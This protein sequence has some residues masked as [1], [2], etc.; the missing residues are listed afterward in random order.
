VS[1]E[2]LLYR[3][4]NE[5]GVRVYRPSGVSDE[6]TCSSDRIRSMLNRFTAEEILASIE[7]GVISVRC[8]FCGKRYTFDPAEFAR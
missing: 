4:F 8:E 5:R 1:V 6:C 2:R 3:L 7:N